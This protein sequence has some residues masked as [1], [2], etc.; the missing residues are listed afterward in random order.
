MTKRVSNCHL[1]KF[2]YILTENFSFLGGNFYQHH[3][4]WMEPNLVRHPLGC[5]RRLLLQGLIVASHRRWAQG[6]RSLFHR[7]CSRIRDNGIIYISILL[8]LDRIRPTYDLPSDKSMMSSWALTLR[9][10]T[11]SNVVKRRP[12][13]I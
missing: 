11:T 2:I 10:P 3:L 4:I 6:Q 13:C 9:S 12:N 8:S 1:L 5:L 7:P